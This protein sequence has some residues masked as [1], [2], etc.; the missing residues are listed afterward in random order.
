MKTFDIKKFHNLTK[1]QLPDVDLTAKYTFYYD[2]TNNIRKFY[3]KEQDFNTSFDLTFVLGGL[4]HSN[5]TKP[6]IE[7][8]FEGIRLQKSISEIKL[9]HL[10]TGDFLECL[11]SDKLNVFLINLL[12][13]KFYVHLST[14][15]VFYY[16]LV[17][18][19]DSAIANSEI[20]Q[21]LGMPFAMHLKNDL[22]R[23]AKIEKEAVVDLFYSFGYPNIKIED[24]GGFIA[25]LYYLFEAYQEI[26]DFHIGLT[27]LRQI[28]RDSERKNDLPFLGD[29]ED[30][31]LLN[32]FSQFY[33]R[34]LYTFKNST[35]IFD[36]EES[37]KAILSEYDLMD[38]NKSK[39]KSYSFVDSKGNKHLQASDIIVGL[40]GKFHT[41]L[42]TSSFGVLQEA[43]L[44][45]N[46]IQEHN[47]ML[48]MKLFDKAHNKNLAFLHSIASIE[49]RQKYQ[50]VENYVT[51]NAGG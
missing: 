33:L 26:P 25:A 39:L 4:V 3:V 8:L 41:F 10:A 14:V 21:Q 36:N 48:L 31:I 51:F 17:D 45:L 22:Y 5:R 43:L 1:L 2:E 40:V 11:T 18:I 32:D 44:R 38:G 49:E 12:K 34:P 29:M 27:S 24:V 28:L 35:H 13:S 9:K 46:S 19:V 16:S 23:L 37:I 30:H 15:N 50:I 6:E 47:L 42:N 20:S 7:T